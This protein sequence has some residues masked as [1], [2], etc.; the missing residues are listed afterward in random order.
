MWDGFALCNPVPCSKTPAL[1][2]R[3]YR[4]GTAGLTN[5]K[6]RAGGISTAETWSA[7]TAVSIYGRKVPTQTIKQGLTYSHLDE[8][9]TAGFESEKRHEQCINNNVSGM[10]RLETWDGG[11]NRVPR[12]KRKRRQDFRTSNYLCSK[13]GQKQH[14][15]S[16]QMRS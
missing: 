11:C 9:R 6:T 1:E 12:A 2:C 10:R 7:L 4:E 14:Q 16:I 8:R 13:L 3:A 15:M 5:F